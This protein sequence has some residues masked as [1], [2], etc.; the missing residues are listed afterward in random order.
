MLS[1]SHENVPDLEL[2]AIRCR[3]AELSIN[4]VID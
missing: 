3:H 2:D 4:Q 1:S